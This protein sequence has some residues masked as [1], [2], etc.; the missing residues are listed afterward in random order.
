[1]S[2]G[3]DCSHNAWHG[4]YS[5][6]MRWRQKVAEVA[7]LPPLELMDGFYAPLNTKHLPT[8]YHGPGT[9][10]RAYGQDSR[11]YLADIDARLPIK[12]ACLK[13]SPLH[14]L[15]SH[16]DCDGEIAADHCGPI[17][18]ELEA[19]IPLMPDDAGGHIGRW[20]DKTAQFVAGL[21]A[22]AEANEPLDFH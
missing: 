19:L 9:R 14:D 22:A 21:R 15:L 10:E 3:L 5:A 12:W 20:R 7:G 11:P 17:A 16:S 1:M 6:F 18:D 8:L 4:A 2:M 13:P